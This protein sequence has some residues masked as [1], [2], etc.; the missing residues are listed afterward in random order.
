MANYDVLG[1]IVLV[2]FLRE[3]RFKEKKKFAQR[4]LNEHKNVRT[5]LEK[6]DK[7]KGRLRIPKSKFIAGENTKE[8]LYN[9]NCCVFRFNVDSCY[10]SPRLSSERKE[11]AGL[12]KK[13][14]KVLVMFGGVGPFAVAIAKRKKAS[15]VC[16]IELGKEANKY[17]IENVKRNKVD[18][19]LIQGDVRKKCKDLNDNTQKS[20]IFGATKPKT[21]SLQRKLNGF[22]GFD[23]IV[24]ARPNLKDSF[25]DC[26]FSIVKKNGI[27]HYYGFYLEEEK[28]KLEELVLL[29]AKKARRKIKILKIKK[30]G[31]IG[32]RKF[33]YR[34][35]F[36]IL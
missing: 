8:V 28:H 19:E 18:V 34:V 2:K 15:L 3:T 27:I 35:D 4:F 7:I 33:R 23:R 21:A 17:A 6:T 16:S 1:N 9:E 24:M 36:K 13:N 30:A 20:T 14:E 25:L 26:A 32:V 31:D 10:F 11:I 12:V 29:E 5:V 22:V